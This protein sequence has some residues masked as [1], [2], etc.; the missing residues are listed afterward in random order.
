MYARVNFACP[1]CVWYACVNFACL[2]CVWYFSASRNRH[3]LFQSKDACQ[4]LEEQLSV[5]KKRVHE[6]ETLHEQAAD[7]RARAAAEAQRIVATIGSK[8]DAQLSDSRQFV[9]D[10]ASRDSVSVVDRVSILCVALQE[11][12]VSVNTLER[13]R[14]E[15]IKEIKAMQGR[16]EESEKEKTDLAGK[17]EKLKSLMGRAQKT[18]EEGK[19]HASIAAQLKDLLAQ[20]WC[21]LESASHLQPTK[22]TSID[23]EY[24]CFLTSPMPMARSST[25]E[26]EGSPS[27]A[28]AS[29]GT[30]G[31]HEVRDGSERPASITNRRRGFW[32]LQ[33]AFLRKRG[34]LDD[35]LEANGTDTTSSAD[36]GVSGK[37][38][39]SV[40][41]TSEEH[42]GRQEED[43]KLAQQ[44][45]AVTLSDG[46]MLPES[47]EE[48]ISRQMKALL[49]KK[50]FNMSTQQ[51]AE[52]LELTQKLAEAEGRLT[53]LG[54]EYHGYKSR[55]LAANHSYKAD[56]ARFTQEM[57][58]HAQLR[59]EFEALRLRCEQ[60]EIRAAR[61]PNDDVQQKL[62]T[63]MAE[64]DELLEKHELQRSSWHEQLSRVKNELAI[65]GEKHADHVAMLRSEH[66]AV[67]AALREEFQTHRQ[68]AR[69]A[70]KEK[71]AEIMRLQFKVKGM[72]EVELSLS[73]SPV[74]AAPNLKSAG[75]PDSN[76]P[77]PAELERRPSQSP[78]AEDSRSVR[79]DLRDVDSLSNHSADLSHASVSVDD[80][81]RAKHHIRRLQQLLR[82]NEVS[83][84][85]HRQTQSD[86]VKRIEELER[87]RNREKGANLEYL[88]NV[89]VKYMEGGDKQGSLLQVI[90]TILQFS[91]GEVDRIKHARA[92]NKGVLGY[93]F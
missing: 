76:E 10:S 11:A 19:R 89:V 34:L 68:R 12:A 42:R 24:W 21:S 56:R 26:A 71:D 67:H 55:A 70:V 65:A 62:E 36:G 43:L 39:P 63:V 14:E 46:T 44:P 51:Q 50:W 2:L 20:H 86:L 27:G 90:A 30:G 4:S 60:L 66:D 85:Q 91:P 64:R 53:K 23:G 49:E 48:E 15:A 13:A 54:E 17:V 31:T 84:S 81:S 92:Q 1:L 22:R 35:S 73:A 77:A 47:L 80:L 74:A 59:S 25:S 7:T 29:A 61:A 37:V 41:R 5:Q 93:I 82:D 8:V 83:L 69:D 72:T 32:A 78:S 6:L 87:T 79:S 52:A 9:R 40:I 38:S 18:I 45:N 75:P 3:G 57:A 28:A 33:S 16:L 88:K 58:A